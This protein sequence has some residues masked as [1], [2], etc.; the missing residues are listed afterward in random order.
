MDRARRYTRNSK[1]GVKGRCAAAKTE[2]YTV[3][4]IYNWGDDEGEKGV[5]QF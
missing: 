3:L 2:R 4:P 1:E 5:M